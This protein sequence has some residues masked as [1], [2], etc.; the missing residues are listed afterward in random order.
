MEDAT[1]PTPADKLKAVH[2]RALRRFDAA[3]LPQ[4]EMRAQAL[5]ARR[6]VAIPGAQWEGP[7]GEQFAN[8]IRVEVPKIGRRIRKIETDYRQN[9]IVPDFRPDG[10]DADQ[11]TADTLDAMHRADSDRFKAQQARDNAFMEACRGGFGAYRLANVL[12]DEGDRDNDDQ[13]I[14]P[15]L[16]IADADQLVYFDP[17]SRLYDKSD[18][19]WA[20]VLIPYTP[21]AYA[22]AWG[23]AAAHW[24]D[25]AARPIWDWYAPEL[26]YACE[27]YEVEQVSS[28][29]YILTQSLT[30]KEERLWSDEIDAAGLADKQAGGWHVRQQ[31]RKRRR[32]HKYILSGAEVLEDMGHIAGEFIPIV[33]VYGQRAFVDGM[34]RFKGEVQDRMDSQRLYNSNVSRLAEIN[35]LSPRERPIFA[36]EQVEGGLGDA[37]A[38]QDIDRHAYALINPL[39]DPN[40]GAIVTMGPI[41]YVKPP[42]VP[43]VTA[44]LMQIANADL[45]EEDQDGAD[46]VKANTSAEAMDIAASRVDA[47]SAI[48][49]DNMRQSVQREGEIYF[50]M[51]RE[52]YADEGREVE[53]MSEDGDDGKAVLNERYVSASG[54]HRIRNDFARARYKVIV[55]VSEATATRRDKTVRSML[56][57]AEIAMQAGDQE[58]A[59]N[60]LLIAVANQDGEGI[61]A[62]H[63]YVRRRGVR[64]GLFAPNEEEQQAIA[65]QQQA[66]AGPD[67][68]MMLAGAQRAMLQAA[69][70]KEGALAGKAVADTAKSEADTAKSKAETLKVLAAIGAVA[71]DA[72]DI[73]PPD[74]PHGRQRLAVAPGEPFAA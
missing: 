7:W 34:E 59:Q 43:Q 46:T 68:A 52:I 62:I 16:L 17:Q 42:D 19:G 31:R 1:A 10:A 29:L 28:L 61:K 69:A 37:W 12:E 11:D 23:E 15:G 26:I 39:T 2:T 58:L 49:L 4:Q 18:A 35:A 30:G 27:W 40:S 25:G 36:P 32:V 60:C 64:S 48:Y 65:A 38:R 70:Q 9:R 22:D 6:F 73:L 44:S 41:G 8:S 5:L 50:G 66:A 74:I 71:N 3:A 54:A 13:R 47:K 21:E 55:S 72:P 33:P 51:A 20:C 14:N 67:P 24:P 57:T 56:S 45:I 63:D 53:T